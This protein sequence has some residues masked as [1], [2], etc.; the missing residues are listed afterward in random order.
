MN[1]VAL[2]QELSVP[3]CFKQKNIHSSL[4]ESISNKSLEQYRQEWIN[5]LSKTATDAR[6]LSKNDQI[7]LALTEW[8]HS[9]KHQYG[10]ILFHLTLTYK[11]FED[12][13][14]PEKII[15]DFFINFYVKHF[16][17]YLLNTRNIH[18]NAKKSIQP[19]TLVFV[20]EHE[21]NPKSGAH[22]FSELL[23]HHAILAVHPDTLDRMN[24]LIGENT[25]ANSKFS[26][27]IMTSDLKEC[28]AMRLL[29]A[30]KVYKRYDYLLFPKEEKKAH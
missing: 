4:L 29:Y 5:Y 7:R 6:S 1:T 26:Y 19:I 14:Y 28:D 11:P 27:K 15:N 17:P 3:D 13:I 16:L 24:E 8:M 2:N 10:R 18:T 20:H 12:R 23:H 9:M 22:K 21:S 25:F 30:S